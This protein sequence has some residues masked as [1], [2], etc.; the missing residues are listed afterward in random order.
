MAQLGLQ[1]VVS[2]AEILQLVSEREAYRQARDFAKS[3]AIRDQLRTMGVELYDKEREWR[4]RDGRRGFLFTAGPSMCTLSDMQIQDRVNQREEARATKNWALADAFRDDLRNQ[5]VELDDKARTWRT[6]SGRVGN[7]TSNVQHSPA[8]LSEVEIRSMVA[9]RERARAMQDFA[10]ADEIRRRLAALGVEVYDRERLWKASDGRQGTIISGGVDPI[11]CHL[12]EADILFRI[13]LREDAR[14]QK[15]WQRADH[16]RDELRLLG[17]ELIDHEQRWLTADGRT[18]AYVPTEAAAAGTAEYGD[19]QQQ[20]QQQ[21][22]EPQPQQW[23]SAD[24]HTGSWGYA[25][26]QQSQPQVQQWQTVHGHSGSYE[27]AQYRDLQR[28][29]ETQTQHWPVVD[30][31]KSVLLA[32]A[33]TA[34][35]AEAAEL[36]RQWQVFNAS[37]GTPPVKAMS[38]PALAQPS[39][40]HTAPPVVQAHLQVYQPTQHQHG[41]GNSVGSPAA[42]PSSAHNVYSTNAVHHS[43][44]SSQGA[45]VLSDASIQALIAGREAV[46]ENRN[47][48][49]A[50]AIREDL[51]NHGIEIWDKQRCWKSSDGR[52]GGS[53][54]SVDVQFQSKLAL[55]IAQTAGYNTGGGGNG[56]GMMRSQDSRW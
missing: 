10:T 49:A 35:P 53:I 43:T 39:A 47:F 12:S 55:D 51:K 25:E 48:E 42:I 5:G 6:A 31:T 11:Q 41:Y 40:V 44:A 13:A 4:C 17:V 2:E 34:D 45:D 16:L 21:H 22:P 36:Q 37:L 3:D 1:L 29:S 33:A 20:Q 14:A 26:Y 54:V 46:R 24:G 19:L 18:G 7:Y 56:A 30:E 50:D 52:R 32:D 9:D 15:D 8:V 38:Q 28:Q 27:P 23:H